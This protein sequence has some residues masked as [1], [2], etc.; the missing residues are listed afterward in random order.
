MSQPNT[1]SSETTTPQPKPKRRCRA[2][3]VNGVQCNAVSLRGGNFCFKHEHHRYPRLPSRSDRISI[4]LLEDHASIQLLATQVAQGLLADT[5]DPARAGKILY[6]CQVAGFSLPRPIRPAQSPDAKPIPQEPVTEVAI[7]S[8]GFPLGPDEK[9]SGPNG[10]FQPSWSFSKYLYERECEDLRV[11][12]PT[13]AADMPPCG[14]MTEEEHKESAEDWKVRT[15]ETVSRLSQEKK[16]R[17]AEETAA[18][19]AAGLPDP[20]APRTCPQGDPRCKGPDSMI[21]CDKCAANYIEERRCA[22]QAAWRKNHPGEYLGDL[23]AVALPDPSPEIGADLLP[24]PASR[25]PLE[26]PSPQLPHGRDPLPAVRD[27]LP[28]CCQTRQ[29]T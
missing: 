20:H 8:D 14:W 15:N 11:P 18:A 27:P 3:R 24:P 12:K 25:P 9:Y 10:A 29:Q 5:L 26:A 13:C 7:H 6:A 17:D 16:C 28:Q 19:I 23:K 2:L 22:A 21:Q 4:P 1:N